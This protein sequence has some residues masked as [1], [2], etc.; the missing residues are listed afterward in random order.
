MR[1]ARSGRRDMGEALGTTKTHCRGAGRAIVRS[2]ALER[3]RAERAPA[4]LRA[5]LETSGKSGVEWYDPLFSWCS[6]RPV[7]PSESNGN[8]D[9]RLRRSA[10]PT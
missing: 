4:P 5:R 1:S 8:Q 10:D 2:Q 3:G 9:G 6:G 7:V